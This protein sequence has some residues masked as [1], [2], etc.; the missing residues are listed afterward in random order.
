MIKIETNPMKMKEYRRLFID[1]CENFIDW[2]E[3]LEIDE[4]YLEL[5]LENGWSPRDLADMLRKEM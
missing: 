5:G 3:G 1:V 4:G 2:P